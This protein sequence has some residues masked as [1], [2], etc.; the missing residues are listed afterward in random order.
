MN[1]GRPI[2]ED[3]LQAYVDGALDERR[4]LAVEDYLRARP[5]LARRIALDR[6]LRA[7]LRGALRPVAEE[8]LPAGLDVRRLLERRT[9]LRKR[10]LGPRR[11]AAALLLLLAGGGAG[12]TLRDAREAPKAGIA[13]LAQEAADSYGVYAPD[14]TRPVEIAA[15]DAEQLVDWASARLQRPVSIPDLSASGYAFIGGRLV[16]TPHGPGVLYLFDDGEGTRLA[17]LSRNM[18]VDREAPMTLQDSGDVT[19]VTWARDGLGFSLVGPVAGSELHPIADAAR[20]QLE[21]AT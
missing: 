3:D 6:D 21:R 13:A 7:A 10:R 4:R 8:P 16:S 5:E 1:V 19:A 14:R 12:W 2:G 20:A 18:A 17:L 15:A 11:A 9:A